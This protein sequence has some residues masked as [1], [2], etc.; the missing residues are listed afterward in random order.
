MRDVLVRVRRAYGAN[1]LHLLALLA[2]FALAGYVVTHLVH[3]PLVVRMLIWFAAAVIGHDLVLFPLYALADRSLRGVLRLLPATRSSGAPVVPPLN[4]VRTPAL[5]AALLLVLFLPGI[6]EQ[7]ARTYR[8]ATGLTQ[9]PYLGRWLV[10]TAVMFGVSAVIYAIRS[11]TASAP[12][13]LAARGL[14]ALLEPGE[15]VVTLAYREGRVTAAACTTRALLYLTGAG[16]PTWARIGWAD[17]A[18]V[19]RR[20]D[21]ASIEVT[22][23][24]GEHTVVRLTDP[25]RLVEV[26]HDF[27]TAATVATVPADI[28]ASEHALITVRRQPDTDHLVWR[29]RLADGA[30]PA[31]PD[32]RSRVDSAI[33]KVGEDL[34]LHEAGDTVARLVIESRKA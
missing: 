20:P 23:L 26:A 31:D 5:G 14:S 27:V 24:S 33:A 3:D 8:S 11:R 9:A 7:G 4:Y 15:R 16:T 22:G 21:T 17:V 12:A 6:I 2:C 30:D 13:R 18:D 10:L 32:V 1:P 29:V 25:G 28:G 19:R 34:G